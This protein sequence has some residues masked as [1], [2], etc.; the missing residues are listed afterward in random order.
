MY[1]D[2][3]SEAMN[4]KEELYGLDR[5]HKQMGLASS[6]VAAQGRSILRNVKD[7]VGDQ[8]QSDDMCL[9]CFGRVG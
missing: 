4:A 7:F 3:F 9:V 6:G 5:L 8:A 2:G 1:T